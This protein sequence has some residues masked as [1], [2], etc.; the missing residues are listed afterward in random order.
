MSVL[1]KS[2][3]ARQV[4]FIVFLSVAVAFVAGAHYYVVDLPVQNEL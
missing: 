3:F 4:L 1:Q 2:L